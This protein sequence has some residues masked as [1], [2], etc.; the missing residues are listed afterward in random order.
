MDGKFVTSGAPKATAGLRAWKRAD[1]R[2]SCCRS[3]LAFHL[4]R[5]SSHL[6]CSQTLLCAPAPQG[7]P[8]CLRYSWLP[9][10]VRR[11]PSADHKHHSAWG[12]PAGASTQARAL[13]RGH[14]QCGRPRPQTTT[15]TRPPRCS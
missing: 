7:S 10:S 4:H 13:P 6:S 8:M 11:K 12:C 14:E 2:S 1:H 3:S 5:N 9:T 15:G